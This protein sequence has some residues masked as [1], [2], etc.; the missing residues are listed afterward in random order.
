MFIVIAAENT[1]RKLLIRDE[2][3]RLSGYVYVDLIAPIPA[4]ISEAAQKRFEN[5]SI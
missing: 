2:N 1:F 3:G 5:P 4:I